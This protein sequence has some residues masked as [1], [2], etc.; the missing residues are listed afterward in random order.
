GALRLYVLTRSPERVILIHRDVRGPVLVG[1]LLGLKELEDLEVV[2][3]HDGHAS[4]PAIPAGDNAL[5]NRVIDLHR[6][7]PVQFVEAAGVE[8]A[9]DLFEH[10]GQG[11]RSTGPPTEGLQ[12]CTLSP[13]AGDIEH[14][15][16][17]LPLTV[18]GLDEVHQRG[19]PAFT[20]VLHLE[21]TRPLVVVLVR[22]QT[23]V[24]HLL[25]VRVFRVA[26]DVD[27]VPAL[28][29]RV[30]L[31]EPVRVVRPYSPALHQPE[32]RELEVVPRVLAPA[33]D[34]AV[35]EVL[36]ALDS[37]GP[38]VTASRDDLELLH[39]RDEVFTLIRE[40]PVLWDQREVAVNHPPDSLGPDLLLAIRPCSAVRAVVDR[41]TSLGELH[42][43][44]ASFA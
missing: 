5:R 30:V 14:A 25:V 20:A 31:E 44:Y 19:S 23:G 26:D 39:H 16:L 32:E 1:V 22:E 2:P 13:D 37:A 27:V 11:E 3:V 42:L 41:K 38:Q 28:D 34:M 12:P 15:V 40:L 18:E 43:L 36:A 33:G 17:V 21:G 35:E 10:H 24:L 4:R 29:D 7:D 6:G 8:D 9:A